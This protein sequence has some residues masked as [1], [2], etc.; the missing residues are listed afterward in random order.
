MKT[1]LYAMI[2][3]LTF[4]TLFILPNSF[5]QEALSRPSVRLVYLHPNDRP[6]QPDK[7]DQLRQL[8][9]DAQQ[10]FSDEMQRHGFGRS[11][12]IFESD[13]EGEPLVH[14]VTGRFAEE[15]YNRFTGHKAWEEIREYFDFDDL[16]HIYFIAIDLESPWEGK[17]CGEAGVTFWPSSGEAPQRRFYDTITQGEEILG[18]FAVI[19]AS[20]RCI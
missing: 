18:G 7:Y 9:K 15:H 3:L 13:K 5:A 12:F 14:R 1:K 8:I 17:H 10:F 20:G 16:H 4:V 6:A 11:T 19:P 2:I